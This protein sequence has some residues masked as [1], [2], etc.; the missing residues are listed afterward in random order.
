MLLSILINER[1]QHCQVG[2]GAHTVLV[3]LSSTV[4]LEVT[5]TGAL[6]VSARS[7]VD[8]LGIL[9]ELRK[10]LDGCLLNAIFSQIVV[11]DDSFRRTGNII[12]TLRKTKQRQ[13]SHEACQ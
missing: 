8:V 2:I 13:Q 3:V 6:R 7:C 1:T 4:R 9:H 5:H 12:L 10:H 11:G